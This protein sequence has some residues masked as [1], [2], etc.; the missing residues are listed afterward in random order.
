[1]RYNVSTASGMI[2][3][4]WGARAARR[5]HARRGEQIVRTHQAQ[6]TALGDA[7]ARVAQP[8]PDLAIALAVDGAASEGGADLV[9]QRRILISSRAQ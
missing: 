7:H 2:V 3:P 5:A 9:Q 1:M 8:R 6:H 4:L